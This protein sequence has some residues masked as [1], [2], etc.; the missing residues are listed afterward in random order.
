MPREHSTPEKERLCAPFFFTRMPGLHRRIDRGKGAALP[1]AAIADLPVCR[2]VITGR[3][4]PT[5]HRILI[6]VGPSMCIRGPASL[7][8]RPPTRQAQDPFRLPAIT[9]SPPAPFGNG[10]SQ[11]RSGGIHSGGLTD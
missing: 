3:P 8:S 4:F 7:P 10:S 1:V 11:L 6:I 5:G 2:P 9:A